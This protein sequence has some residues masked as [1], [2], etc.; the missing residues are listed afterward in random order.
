MYLISPLFTGQ[1]LTWD[2]LADAVV[3]SFLI[4]S[5]F[6]FISTSVNA[7]KV[8]ARSKHV[9]TAELK[10]Y[11]LDPRSIADARQGISAT[12]E[13]VVDYGEEAFAV[14]K[15]GEA[16]I[17]VAVEKGFAEQSVKLALDVDKLAIIETV[18]SIRLA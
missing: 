11:D 8:L 3:D 12:V 1:S 17:N 6:I 7:I 9:S 4:T 5:A 10:S 18:R 14:C 16:T 2:G 13:S 15:V